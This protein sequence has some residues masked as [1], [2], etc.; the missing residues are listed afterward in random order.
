MSGGT[1]CIVEQL[2]FAMM[3]SCQA[4]SSGLTW[5]TTSGTAGSIRQ[6]LELSM[7]A[8]AARG[9]LGRELLRGPGAGAEQRDVDALEGVRRREADLELRVPRP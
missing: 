7:T 3:P 4:R 9:R 6:A 8:A 1:S 2:G 5:D